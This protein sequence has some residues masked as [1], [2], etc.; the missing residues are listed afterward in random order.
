MNNNSKI[1]STF[2][3]IQNKSEDLCLIDPMIL[4]SLIITI[5]LMLYIIGFKLSKEDSK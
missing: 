3:V 2:N 5:C 1:V 4:M